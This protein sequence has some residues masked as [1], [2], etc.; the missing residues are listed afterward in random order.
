M[1]LLFTLINGE[2]IDY[3]TEQ[4][5]VTI[6]RSSK[7]D[8]VIPHESMSRQHCKIELKD[9]EVFITDLGSINGVYIDGIKIAANSSVP[10]YTYL[11][12]SFGFVSSTQLVIDESTRQKALTP[13]FKFSKGN[14]PTQQNST[15]P[16]H[17]TKNKPVQPEKAKQIKGK[18]P[19]SETSEKSALLIKGLAFVAILV[20]IYFL[21]YGDNITSGD[22]SQTDSE[23][24]NKSE[25]F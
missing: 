24:I 6:G 13:D 14:T 2:E 4:E 9:G 5:S 7:C 8:V 15:E 20:A 3:S 21:L 17:R 18:K 10:F 16:S 12:L 25:P 11:H 23:R 1:R 22:Q 19:N